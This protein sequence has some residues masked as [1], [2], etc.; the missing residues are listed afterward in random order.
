M[1]N[2]EV[3]DG[4]EGDRKSD[5]G[6]IGIGVHRPVGWDSIVMGKE[7]LIRSYRLDREIVGVDGDM[8]W[9]GRKGIVSMTFYARLI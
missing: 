1:R 6:G 4:I 5:E 9:I 2:R 8:G 7:L 3:G